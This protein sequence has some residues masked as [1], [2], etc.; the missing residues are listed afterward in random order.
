MHCIQRAGK[1]IRVV[2]AA[3]MAVAAAALSLLAGPAMA[4]PSGA[5]PSSPPAG[6]IHAQMVLNCD[7]MSAKAHGYAVS[8]GYCPTSTGSAAPNAVA[9][10]NCGDSWIYIFDDTEGNAEIDWGFD[11]SLGAVVYRS[12]SVGYSGVDESGGWPDAAW[13]SSSSYANART[14]IWVGPYGEAYATVGGTVTLW[15][16]GQCTLLEPTDSTYMGS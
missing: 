13:M 14:G 1:A 5:P 4:S 15:W 16:G 8:H 7:T 2:L 3:M 9:Y 6:A 10:G 12:L 11:S